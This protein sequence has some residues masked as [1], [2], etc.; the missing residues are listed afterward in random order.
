MAV[1]WKQLKEAVSAVSSWQGR[2]VI[3]P[4]N[5]VIM[6]GF[7]LPDLDGKMSGEVVAELVPGAHLVKAF[8]TLTPDLLAADPHEATA[9]M[10]V[11]VAAVSR[12]CIPCP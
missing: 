4:T 12:W 5:P 11:E 9:L 8:N 6:P 7:Q 10:K 2:I 1:P 3:D